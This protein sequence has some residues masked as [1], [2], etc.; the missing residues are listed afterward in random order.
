MNPKEKLARTKES[1]AHGQFK[2]ERIVRPHP[3]NNIR[4]CPELRSIPD[5][6]FPKRITV[7]PDGNRRFAR[8][9]HME[10][11]DG[12]QKGADK[13]VE[14]LKAF[15]GLPIEQVMVWGF[16]SDNWDRDSR[17]IDA[18]MRIMDQTAKDMLPDLMERGG[19]LIHLGRADRIPSYL[20]ETLEEVESKTRFNTGQIVALGID[21]GGDDQV[22]RMLAAKIINPDLDQEQ[23]RDGG[24]LI[25]PA[26]LL[27]R[28]GEENDGLIHTSDI[29]WI[30]GKPT[31]IASHTKS[32]PALTRADVAA[33][34]RKFAMRQRRMGK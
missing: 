22:N 20:R 29:G 21:F 4:T 28:T 3:Y 31:L 14:L 13:V 16:S 26:E 7:V 6:K 30:N 18:I 5:Y 8:K 12:H 11:S 33:D 17:E 25:K 32:F 9:R 23:L 2:V 1:L 19:R 10:V 24:G 34:I 15:A 27:I